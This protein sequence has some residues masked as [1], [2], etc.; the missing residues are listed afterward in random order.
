MKIEL[1]KRNKSIKGF[2]VYLYLKY[3]LIPYLDLRIKLGI[4]HIPKDSKYLNSKRNM[5]KFK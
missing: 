5:E 3:I 4:P 1:D 2:L